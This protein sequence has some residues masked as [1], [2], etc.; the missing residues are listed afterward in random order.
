MEASLE[1]LL[2]NKLMATAGKNMIATPTGAVDAP[3]VNRTMPA[4]VHNVSQLLAMAR[5]PVPRLATLLFVIIAFVLTLFILILAAVDAFRGILA[6]KRRASRKN[7]NGAAATS[8]IRQGQDMHL[9]EEEDAP[10]LLGSGWRPFYSFF[11]VLA[12]MCQAVYLLLYL[13]GS[14]GAVPRQVQFSANN[15]AFA[16]SI[17]AALFLVLA[18]IPSNPATRLRLGSTMSNVRS[19]AWHY[20]I[21]SL[22]S[23]A[24]AL[25]ISLMVFGSFRYLRSFGHLDSALRTLIDTPALCSGQQT[26]P[27]ND[28]AGSCSVYTIAFLL[29]NEA[30]AAKANLAFKGIVLV[31]LGVLTAIVAHEAL[32]ALRYRQAALTD[33]HM[34]LQQARLENED[35][36]FGL[37][38]DAGSLSE[39]SGHSGK[40]GD[41]RKSVFRSGMSA[42][43]ER[44]YLRYLHGLHISPMYREGSQSSASSYAPTYKS[45]GSSESATRKPIRKPPPSYRDISERSPSFSDVDEV[46]TRG[47][48]LDTS[49]PIGGA[50]QR[51]YGCVDVKRGPTVK[52]ERSSSK[53]TRGREE[54]TNNSDEDIRRLPGYLNAHITKPETAARKSRDDDDGIDG[55]TR[56]RSSQRLGRVESLAR[57][58]SLNMGDIDI[59]T[60]DPAPG[61]GRRKPRGGR[62]MGSGSAP[63]STSSGPR[64]RSPSTYTDETSRAQ[65]QADDSHSRWSGN[66]YASSYRS[67][68]ARTLAAQQPHPGSIALT[69]S[70][71]AAASTAAL[72]RTAPLRYRMQINR[73]MALTAVALFLLVI[74]VMLFLGNN[75]E[76]GNRP[77]VELASA[78]WVWVLESGLHAAVL[79]LLIARGSGA[80][81]EIPLAW[82]GG[83]PD[84]EQGYLASKE[85]RV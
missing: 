19:G 81:E 34:Q 17:S 15:V 80:V 39:K 23:L 37:D 8:R 2:A 40:T 24:P 76:L 73:A 82:P 18:M 16:S 49:D 22:V 63:S 83:V 55:L 71:A 46:D 59:S 79:G 31:C 28:T 64:S 70:A 20:T 85:E 57:A 9:L 32:R 43:A 6:L 13:Q 84:L 45:T 35:L 38:S 11:V 53:S 51:Q 27:G 10:R 56:M 3:D 12:S 7:K 60:I 14:R 58:R 69:L 4:A 75:L 1:F 65:S 67:S 29:Q 21:V 30:G 66:G 41:S 33:V 50:L 52:S 68:A 78:I 72:A 77:Q 42:Q 26:V 44:D 36:G 25:A 74:V 47:V 54:M 5:A 48:D 61:S 62:P